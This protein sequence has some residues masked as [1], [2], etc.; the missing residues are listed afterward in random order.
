MSISS[1]N[2]KY[3]SISSNPAILGTLE[4]PCADIVNP[5]RNGR[6]YSEELWEKVFSD[7]IVE[8]QIQNGGI[9]GE[10][11]HPLDDR[12]EI[13]VEKVAIVMKEKPTK[14]D[15][16][17]WAKFQILNTPVGRIIKTLCDAGFNI[18]VSSRGSG[19]IIT[20]YNGQE[21]V[22]PDRYDFKCFDCALIPAVKAARMKYVSE[23]LNNKTRKSLR[24]ALD[25]TINNASEKDKKIMIETLN[26]LQIPYSQSKE[27]VENIKES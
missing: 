7:P 8:E 19:D 1:E 24:E 12:E 5:T 16:K 22:D 21:S 23:G 3:N 26:D 9:M 27:T 17:L 15:G 20:D 10:G 14:K 25:N 6:K 11:M 13:D 2:F 18:G 4:G